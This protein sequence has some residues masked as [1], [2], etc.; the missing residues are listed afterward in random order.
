MLKITPDSGTAA[1]S[2]LRL[3]GRIAGPWIVELEHHC[4]RLLD[5]GRA[6]TLDLSGVS[7][8]EARGVALLRALARRRVALTGTS[9]FVA[10]QLERI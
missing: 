3:E 9:A 5:G 1:G 2:V 10:V 7:Y 4:A 6:L 8:V